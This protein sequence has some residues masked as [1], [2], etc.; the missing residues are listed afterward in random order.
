MSVE[1]E[2]EL[3][4]YQS[5]HAARADMLW[6]AGYRQEAIAAYRCAMELTTNTAS[7]HFL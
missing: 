1:I 7:L 4:T 3:A 6:R 5:L 2:G